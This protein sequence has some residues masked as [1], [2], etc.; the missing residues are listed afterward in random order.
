MRG[1]RT[2]LITTHYMD[3]AEILGDRIAIMH[4]GTLVCYGTSLFLKKFYG[5]GY[6]LQ[7]LTKAGWDQNALISEIKPFVPLANI[8]GATTGTAS[9]SLP[10]NNTEV[11]TKLFSH[12][13]KNKE[14]LG[15]VNFS[16]SITSL[17]D[18]FLIVGE[19]SDKAA[20]KKSV[21]AETPEYYKRE[22][23]ST[24]FQYPFDLFISFC[25]LQMLQRI[26][27]KFCV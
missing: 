8:K 21:V 25:F 3:E 10:T 5:M 18:V 14:K 22:F 16:V 9:V 4:H 15:I 20:R 17:E 11:L 23:E 6:S 27:R 7:I 24:S 26:Q 1:E 19:V 2:I 13:D 12:L